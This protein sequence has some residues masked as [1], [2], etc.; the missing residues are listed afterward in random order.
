MVLLLSFQDRLNRI[1][2]QLDREIDKRKSAKRFNLE[3][4]G[5]TSTDQ[6]STSDS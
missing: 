6:P 2:K 1:H 4:S 3:L 5:G